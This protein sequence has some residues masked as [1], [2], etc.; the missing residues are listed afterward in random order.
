MA[1]QIT[2]NINA[3]EHF[4]Q[5]KGWAIFS[6]KDIGHS[7]QVIVTDGST[8]LPVNFYHTGKIVV[9]GKP[10]E[11][12]TTL[13]EWANRLQ[14]ELR[15]ESV[16]APARQ[17]RVAKYLVIP[18]NIDKIHDVVRR[19]PGEVIEKETGGPAEVY[20][21]EARHEEHRV[22][23][24]QYSS[25]TLMVQGLSSPYFDTVCE[26]L[27]E[28]LT[29]S[30]SDRAGRF[31]VGKTQHTAVTVYLEQPEAENEALQ[32]LLQQIDQSVLDFLYENDQRTLLA[33]AGV[34]NA[35]QKT[36]QPLPDYSVV[37][38]PFAKAFEGFLIS[39]AIHL[40]LTTGNALK[41]RAN[42][43]EIGNWLDTIKSRLPDVKRY[44]EIHAAL[45]DAWQCRHKA[46]HS[47]FA[48]PWSTLK[49]LNEA[50][51]EIAT[52]LRAMKRAHRVFVEQGVKLVSSSPPTEVQPQPK[53][54]EERK[55]K[56]I[57][58]GG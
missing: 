23:I 46:L 55:Q 24:T 16:G 34:W 17:N 28:H 6:Q 39:L 33:A 4:L 36:N 8:R 38:M 30:F 14:A 10:S 48:H 15:S 44:G 22:T 12:K 7:R 42:K 11:M 3:L 26:A 50:E 53:P 54:S 1:D 51:Q 9:Q 5:E 21:V 37:V 52:I 25:G 56:K 19:L 18:G 2:C 32:W 58:G 43:I 57:R 31:I 47:D 27:D 45:E 49:T 29:Q 40:E 13:T 20:R 35:F 41:Q